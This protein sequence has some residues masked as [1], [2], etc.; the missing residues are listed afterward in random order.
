MVHFGLLRCGVREGVAD[1]F[2][3]MIIVHETTRAAYGG[4]Y[5]FI[6]LAK[7]M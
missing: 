4:N 6:Q 1:E 5:D 3:N 2:M 7:V